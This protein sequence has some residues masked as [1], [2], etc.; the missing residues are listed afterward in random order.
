MSLTRLNSLKQGNI[1]FVDTSL[2]YKVYELD[3]QSAINTALYME[4]SSKYFGA[5]L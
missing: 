2:Q 3:M 4:V 5:G 1:E